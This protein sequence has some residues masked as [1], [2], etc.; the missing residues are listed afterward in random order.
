M[1]TINTG[2]GQ[3]GAKN[4]FATHAI[5]FAWNVVAV[6]RACIGAGSDASSRSDAAYRLR[7][8]VRLVGWSIA[9]YGTIGRYKD[10]FGK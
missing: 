9:K 1:G 10:C 6:E 4:V 5:L 8:V 7:R 2:T 3:F